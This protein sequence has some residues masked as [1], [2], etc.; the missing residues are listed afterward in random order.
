MFPLNFFPCSTTGSPRGST[1]HSELTP[2]AVVY[3]TLSHP[4]DCRVFSAGAS[5]FC[6]PDI[7]F[8]HVKLIR[9]S[10]PL[11]QFTT[12]GVIRFFTPFVNVV[13]F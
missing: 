3:V 1:I 11:I 10:R 9:A 5:P 4:N 12:V 13:Y 7:P 6:D 2:V 8:G